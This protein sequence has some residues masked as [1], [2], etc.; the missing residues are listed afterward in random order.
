MFN[1]ADIEKYFSAEKSFSGFFMII[2]AAAIVLAIILFFAGKS[3][4]FKG[5]AIVLIIMSI[6]QLAAS[7]TVYKR[8]DGDRKRLTYAYDMNPPVLKNTELPRME[9]VEKTFTIL[10][11]GEV[12]L[13][14]AGVGL[15]LY[16]RDNEQL[17]F[18]KG[19]GLALAIEAAVMLGADLYARGNATKY[20]NG[21]KAYAEAPASAV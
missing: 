19:F 6:I 1:K 3:N 17:A 8:S 2:A 11:I 7:Y 5:A 16:F 18:W 14:L 20:I 10:L 21:L 4:A 9:K 12:V 13:L 15:F